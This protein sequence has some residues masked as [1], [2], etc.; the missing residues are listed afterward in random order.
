MRT[1]ALCQRLFL[2]VLACVVAPPFSLG[3]TAEPANYVILLDMSASMLDPL[4]D[5]PRNVAAQQAV[6]ALEPALVG[7]TNVSIVYFAD[8]T[9]R[10]DDGV[11]CRS[12]RPVVRIGEAVTPQHIDSIVRDLGEPRGRKTNIAHAL[13]TA[14]RE[15]RELG[16]G[17]VVL[18]SDGRENC[19]LD[20][21]A[22][23]RDLGAAGIPVD[24]IGIGKAGDFSE[25]GRIALAGGGAFRLADSANALASGIAG[26][27]NLPGPVIEPGPAPAAAPIPAP[28]APAALPVA[29]VAAGAGRIPAVPAPTV[30]PLVLDAAASVAGEHRRPVAVEI[31]LDVSGSMAG[32]LQGETKMV[33]ARE[34]LSAALAGL[35]SDAF[36]VGLRAY[37]FD[38]TLPK[39][40]EASC[41]NTELLIPVASNQ[42]PAIRS[43]VSGLVP[44]GYTPLARSLE[45]AGQDL[46]AVDSDRQVIILLTDG[47]ESCG[48]DPQAVAADLRARGIDI[49]VHIVGFDLAVE[50]A[51]AMQDVAAAGGGAYYDARD[52]GEL[53][54]ALTRVVEV[55]ADKVDPDW[56][57]TISPVAGGKTPGEAPT[58]APGTYTLADHLPQGEQRYFR[59]ATTQAQHGVV[60]G[61]IQ[62]RRLVRAGEEQVESDSGYAQYA[63]RFYTPDGEAIGGR[64]V[65]LH[66][67]PGS[68]GHVGY[69]DL[70]GAGFLFAIGSQYDRVHKDAL[71]NVAI[72]DAGDQF[73]GQEAP[74]DLSAGSPVIDAGTPVTGHLGDGDR[75]DVY[76]VLFNQTVGAVNVGLAFRE[77]EFASRVT[78]TG[79]AT[80]RRIHSSASRGEDYN[81]AVAVPQE[82]REGLSIEIRS[83]NPSLREMF[84]PYEL[85]VS[86]EELP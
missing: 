10:R 63:I 68:A 67:E 39:T 36:I 55:A 21:V 31:I 35:D 26:A 65:R 30:Q 34:A 22:L 57:R 56:L 37:G 8:G 23:A 6:K 79:L 54:V 29:P 3:G 43:N 73:V 78:V 53:A 74:A 71:F 86:T 45:L 58:L 50:E 28:A 38:S 80:G 14:A 11:N 44:Y 75:R 24:T 7:Q 41:P 64:T 59:V 12:S 48:G 76:K 9:D 46:L 27:A 83:N 33:L 15:L 60:R 19:D 82:E 5:T 72:T 1:L 4:G 42:V 62:S 2:V 49:E 70:D 81:L 77:A 66:G 84:S 17:K 69:S 18:I 20:P 61:L 85:T 40:A 51:A 13:D 32:R 47:E 25:L 16:A 52:T